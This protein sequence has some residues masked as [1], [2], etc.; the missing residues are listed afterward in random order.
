MLIWLSWVCLDLP[1]AEARKDE[2]HISRLDNTL[3]KLEE[4]TG[5]KLLE[6]FNPDITV[7]RLTLDPVIVRLNTEEC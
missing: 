6:G 7:N 2:K 3:E 5:H 4:R 1:L